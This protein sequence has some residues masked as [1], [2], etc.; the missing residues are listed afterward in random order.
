MPN[1]AVALNAVALQFVSVSAEK[2][3]PVCL[4][5]VVKAVLML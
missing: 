5:A 3:L 2:L 4:V 1:E